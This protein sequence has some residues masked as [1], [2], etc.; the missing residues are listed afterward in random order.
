MYRESLIE[1]TTSLR[2]FAYSLCGEPADADDL[3][4]QTIEKLLAE[5]IDD[6]EQA[7][8]WAFRVCRNLWIDEVRKKTTSRNYS[9][10][11]RSKADETDT[12]ESSAMNHTLIKEI[13][14]ALHKLPE[15]QRSVLALV[16]I[17]GFSYKEAA[18]M[19]QIPVGTIMSRLAR[20]RAQLLLTIPLSLVDDY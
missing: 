9:E 6:I 1:L 11:F 16:A 18:E 15:S 5:D 2:R 4:Q 14:Q 7:R 8:K 17:E 12:T 3:V 10:E 13:N 20:A 19:L